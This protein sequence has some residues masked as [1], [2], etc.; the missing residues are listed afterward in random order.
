LGISEAGARGWDPLRTELPLCL[1][2]GLLGLFVLVE[3]RAAAPLV[4]PRVFRLRSVAVVNTVTLLVT[5]VMGALTLLLSVFFQDVGRHSPLATGA[6]LLPLGLVTAAVSHVSPRLV[7]AFGPR[8][9]LAG[10]VAVFAG[11]LLVLDAAVRSGHDA[12]LLLGMTACG[13]G[14]GPFFTT[15]TVTAT[16][17]LPAADQGLAGALI[18]TA[19]QIGTALGIAFLVSLAE[20]H[21]DD[22]ASGIALAMRTGA[23]ILVASAFLTLAALHER[24]SRHDPTGA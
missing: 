9:V 11:G 7:V 21:R 6:A 22:T 23:V 13:V 5:G 24:R 3:R 2:L 20:R 4:P 8:R 19:T 14:F 12:L 15:A 16:Q 10:G 18:S 1:G 17:D